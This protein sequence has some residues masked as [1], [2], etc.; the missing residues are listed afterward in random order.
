MCF[1]VTFLDSWAQFLSIFLY[2]GFMFFFF[3]QSILFQS[4]LLIQNF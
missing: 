3:L 4:Q 2:S 1:P